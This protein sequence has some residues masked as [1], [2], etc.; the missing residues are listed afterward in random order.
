MHGGFHQSFVGPSQLAEDFGISD[1]LAGD[2]LLSM[3][4]F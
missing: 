4:I 3:S 1:R 2:G